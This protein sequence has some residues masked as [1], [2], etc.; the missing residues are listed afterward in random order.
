[1]KLQLTIRAEEDGEP[2]PN[3]FVVVTLLDSD[4]DSV[5]KVLGKSETLQ[6]ASRPDFTKLFVVD[7]FR[8][9]RPTHLSVSL[10]HQPKKTNLVLPS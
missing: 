6:I 3:P 1:M 7:D 5:P 8:L 9:G 10:F 2:P 4:G